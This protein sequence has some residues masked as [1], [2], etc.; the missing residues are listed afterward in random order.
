MQAAVV[1][2]GYVLASVLF[3]FG[4]KGLAHP[5]SAVQGNALGALGMLLAVVLTLLDSQHNSQ[6]Y[7]KNVTS[8]LLHVLH[9]IKEGK[10]QQESEDPIIQSTLVTHA[11]EIVHPQVRAILGL[12]PMHCCGRKE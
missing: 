11:G 5:R 2:L 3:I 4:L 9:V 1:N 10:F 6:L 7:A 12:P 8:F